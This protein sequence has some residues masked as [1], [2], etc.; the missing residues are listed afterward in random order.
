MC[1][2]VPTMSANCGK[3][4][5]KGSSGDSTGMFRKLIFSVVFLFFGKSFSAGN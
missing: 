3:Y 1:N 5:V 4:S 2:G